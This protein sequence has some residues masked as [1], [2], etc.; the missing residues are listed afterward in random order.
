[1]GGERRDSIRDDFSISMSMKSKTIQ[2]E[3]ESF[4]NY[5]AYD[6]ILIMVY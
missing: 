6:D 3:I 2:I 1:M 5:R 4:G